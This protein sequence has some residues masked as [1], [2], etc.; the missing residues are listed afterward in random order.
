MK[1][2]LQSKESEMLSLLKKLVSIDSGSAH[3][4]G[5]DEIGRV[6]RE[7]YLQIGFSP[8]IYEQSGNG[9]HIV[10]TLRNSETTPSI[11]FVA[12]MDTVFKTGTAEQRPFTI[13]GERA[14]GPGVIDMKASQVA[15]LYAMKTLA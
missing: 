8:K 15:L 6:L 10:L 9:N 13:K 7:Q 3:K 2:Y 12:H 11:L 1:N 5:I 14:Y 4:E